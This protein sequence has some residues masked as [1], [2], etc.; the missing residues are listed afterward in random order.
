MATNK[1]TETRGVVISE[2]PFKESSKILSIYTEELGKISVMV[3]GAMAAKSPHISTSQTFTHGKYYLTAGRSFYYLNKGILID[4]NLGLRKNYDK[5][6]YCSLIVEL[7]N[8]T[9]IEGSKNEKIY[10]L[11]SKSLELIS[12]KNQDK[13][14]LSAFLLKYVSYMGYRPRIPQKYIEP[15]SFVPSLGG[16][17]VGDMIETGG[18]ELNEMEIEILNRLLYTPLDELIKIDRSIDFKKILDILIQYVQVNLD[19]NKLYSL[20]LM[21]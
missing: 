5:I 13:L 16:I 10:G 3:K 17:Q 14:L 8:R 11:L 2:M 15:M 18:I 21:K 20:Q 9:T 1:K 19:I 6:I 7:V 4:S 12:S